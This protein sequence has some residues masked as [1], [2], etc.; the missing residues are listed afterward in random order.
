[1]IY[2]LCSALL[3]SM[4]FLVVVVSPSAFSALD[5]TNSSKFI[6]T[7]FPKVFL[8]GLVFSILIALVSV[9]TSHHF[10][11]VGGIISAF[12]FLVN[13]NYLTPM[14]N[15]SRDAAAEKKFRLLHIV[16][17]SFFVLSFLTITACTIHSYINNY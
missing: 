11:T 7:I 2:F 8:F 6:R 14:I 9:F 1:M 4:F 5:G 15:R 13:R 12:L 16:S 17:V 10:S 3:G